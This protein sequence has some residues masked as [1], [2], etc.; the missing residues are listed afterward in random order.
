VA[1]VAGVAHLLTATS[2]CADTKGHPYYQ[3]RKQIHLRNWKDNQAKY[4]HPHKDCC[5]GEN[6]ISSSSEVQDF[7]KGK[8]N[9][10]CGYDASLERL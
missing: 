8:S 10:L 1:L 6:T 9:K 4:G 5:C 2:V 7:L 3:K